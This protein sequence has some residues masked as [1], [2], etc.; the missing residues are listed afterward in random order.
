MLPSKRFKSYSRSANGLQRRYVVNCTKYGPCHGADH[1]KV[2]PC[3]RDGI[4][5]LIPCSA[6]RLRTEK[7]KSYTPPPG[8]S[9]TQQARI[10][11]F[12]TTGPNNRFI[13][14]LSV[15]SFMQVSNFHNS[16]NTGCL[17]WEQ[18]IC[19]QETP[20]K[21]QKNSYH[22]KNSCT[23]SGNSTI[24]RYKIGKKCSTMCAIRIISLIDQ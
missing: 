7:Y 13:L 23:L 16:Q 12:I 3:P 11:C 14:L 21:V 9:F 20:Q 1:T 24:P 5:K 10:N 19:I 6:A 17:Y 8:F 22:F 15:L 18:S 2:V 4:L